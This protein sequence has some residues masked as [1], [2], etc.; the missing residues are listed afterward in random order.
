MKRMG[1]PVQARPPSSGSGSSAATRPVP[2]Q[3]KSGCVTTPTGLPSGATRKARPAKA[4]RVPR[5]A[6]MGLTFSFVTMRPLT[7]PSTI[8][9]A[10]PTMSA[11]SIEPCT[12]GMGISKSPGMKTEP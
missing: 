11:P 5:V 6:M 7:M 4:A 1:T 10:M 8:P 2:S 3:V 12:K 9:V